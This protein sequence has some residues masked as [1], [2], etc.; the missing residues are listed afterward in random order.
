MAKLAVVFDITLQRLNLVVVPH[1]LCLQISGQ[2]VRGR[3]TLVLFFEIGGQIVLHMQQVFDRELRDTKQF[4]EMHVGEI[5]Q[6]CVRQQWH[7]NII[8][9]R[10]RQVRSMYGKKC[11]TKQRWGSQPRVHPL[12][13]D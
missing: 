5:A 11:G 3:K 8:R 12:S 1:N 6:I 4:Q 9:Y 13:T 7:N 2:G 10:V